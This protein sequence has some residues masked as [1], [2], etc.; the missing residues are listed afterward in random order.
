MTHDDVQAIA[1]QV[2]EIM[3]AKITSNPLTDEER[4]WVRLAIKKEAQSI[5]FRTAVI[6]KGLFALLWGAMAMLGYLA[7]QFLQSKGFKP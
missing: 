3:Q 1:A 6:E 7:M 4:T 5:A 2:A